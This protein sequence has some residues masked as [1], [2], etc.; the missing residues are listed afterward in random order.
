MLLAF[1][2]DH[3]YHHS[4]PDYAHCKAKAS[5]MFCKSTQFCACCGHVIPANLIISSA[6]LTFCLHFARLPSLGIQ[7]VTLN[8]QRLS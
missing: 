8:D 1:I 3:Q 5:P 6:H 4:Q 7:S 2:P